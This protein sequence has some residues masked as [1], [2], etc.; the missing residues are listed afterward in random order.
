[1]RNLFIFTLFIKVYSCTQHEDLI[2]FIELFS[3]VFLMNQK[4]GKDRTNR[5][6]MYSSI[7]LDM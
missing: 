1:M 5:I 6:M 7:L 4:F 2:F 3:H